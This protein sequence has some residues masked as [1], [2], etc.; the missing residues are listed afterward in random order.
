MSQ[1][2]WRDLSDLTAAIVDMSL[3]LM[4]Y[5]GFSWTRA[6]R[7]LVSQADTKELAA[8][9][10]SIYEEFLYR[11]GEEGESEDSV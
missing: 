9:K 2:H 8:A 10:D 5:K 3:N 11:G 4:V 7:F 6:W 1:I